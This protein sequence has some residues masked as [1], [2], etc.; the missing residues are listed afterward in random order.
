M[1]K[2]ASAN[3]IC[4]APGCTNPVIANPRGRPATYCSPN[5]RSSN[6]RTSRPRRPQRLTVEVDHAPT[7]SN[8]RPAGRI[9]MV[10]LRRGQRCVVVADGLGRPSA[11]HL[12]NQITELI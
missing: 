8:Q 1:T 4:A 3:R 10:R 5:C 6:K 12:A 2:A 11:E 7:Q 9:W